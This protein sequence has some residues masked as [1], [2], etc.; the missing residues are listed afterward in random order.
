MWFWGGLSLR[1]FVALFLPSSRQIF[2]LF[3][4]SLYKVTKE[5]TPLY[6]CDRVLQL[7]PHLPW[8]SSLKGGLGGPGPSEPNCSA[9]CTWGR[10]RTSRWGPLWMPP[11]QTDLLAL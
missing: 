10:G 9:A 7:H 6:L 11:T 1:H 3:L 2:P 5:V 8:P 4:F